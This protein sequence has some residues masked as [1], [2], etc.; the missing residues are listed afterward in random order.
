MAHGRTAELFKLFLLDSLVVFFGLGV[1]W[2]GILFVINPW[3]DV[4]SGTWHRNNPFLLAAAN[5]EK[6]GLFCI[7]SWKTR[8]SLILPLCLG[9]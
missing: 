3:S 8:R 5:L 2:T 6:R 1:A 9:R 7:A 4:D